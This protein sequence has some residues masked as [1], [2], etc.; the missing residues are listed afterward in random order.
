MPMRWPKQSG[1]KI[2]ITLTP[3]RKPRSTRARR[4]AAGARLSAAMGRVPGFSAPFPSMAFPSAL[5]TRPRHSG[6][7]RMRNGPSS[8]TAAPSEGM[9]RS[10]NGFTSTCKSATRMISARL[11]A[12]SPARIATVS[13]SRASRERPRTAIDER[14]TSLTVPPIPVSGSGAIV[15]WRT[16]AA[17]RVSGRSGVIRFWNP[18]S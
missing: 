17:R 8:K 16:K 7:G 2:S 6:A 11:G 1:V 5:M 10:S 3:V 15:C 12:P 13:P 18:A 9:I 4:K 14:E